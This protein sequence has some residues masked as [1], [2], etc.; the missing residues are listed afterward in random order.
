M[1]HRKKNKN[2]VSLTIK[3][4]STIFLYKR[5][6]TVLSLLDYR[7]WQATDF[8]SCLPQLHPRF[9]ENSPDFNSINLE[10]LV[11]MNCD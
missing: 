2:N 8:I 6:S 4:I 7:S 10:A 5:F 11:T 1:S 3:N 9:N